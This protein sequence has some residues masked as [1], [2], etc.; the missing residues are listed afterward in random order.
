MRFQSTREP[1]HTT[2]V[3]VVL[4]RGLAPDGG[5]YVPTRWPRFEVADFADHAPVAV[6]ETL[7]A[8][9]FD[10]SALSDRLDS[11]CEHALSFPLP[12]RP[13]ARNAWMLELFHGPTC[14][15]KDVGARFLAGCLDALADEAGDRTI[16]L[17]A[18]SGD[19]G[20]AVAA[21]FEGMA[22]AGAAVLFP[23]TGVSPRQR[24]QLTCWEQPIESYAVD[25][26]FD[27]CQSLVKQAF[28]DP[29]LRDS[30][31]LTSANSISVGRLLPQMSYYAATALA[32][33]AETGERPGFIVPTGNL[34]NALACVWARS[35]GL[36]I[37][38]VLL[39]TND[40]RTITRFLASGQWAPSATIA[41]LASAMDVGNPSNMERLRHQYPDATA[42]NGQ[43]AAVS[44]DDDAI[45]AAIVDADVRHGQVLCPHTACAYHAWRTLPPGERDRPW[46]LVAT[47][48]PAKFEQIVEPLVGRPVPVPEP[49]AALLDRPTREHS[50]AGDLASL[51]EALVAAFG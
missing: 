33:H 20:A 44:V 37:G 47:A 2:S 25:G 36:P 19:T 42:V 10:D 38:D 23:E 51:R 17:T 29:L 1:G 30:L 43:V 32:L 22:S 18:T 14:A 50:L 31:T 3:D 9:F 39:A 46:V 45:R 21:A 41:T 34:G 6:A 13:L 49:L 11:I 12:A 35:L 5:L 26:P 27:L 48:H 4:R 40:N 15:F 7:L 16:V 24:H 28:V 8:P